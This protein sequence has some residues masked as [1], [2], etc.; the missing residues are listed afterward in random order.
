MILQICVFQPLWRR[1]A[2][3]GKAKIDAGKTLT[4]ELFFSEGLRVY[5]SF[6]KK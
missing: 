6:L 3:S 5:D 1:K 4:K 2:L